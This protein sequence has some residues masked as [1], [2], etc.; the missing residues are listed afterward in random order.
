MSSTPRESS[1]RSLSE[2]SSKET[3]ETH[4]F[5]DIDHQLAQQF[6]A[7]LSNAYPDNTDTTLIDDAAQRART[8]P[9]PS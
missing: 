8:E 1:P 3:T 5:E 2:F 9:G 6:E 7:E 4:S